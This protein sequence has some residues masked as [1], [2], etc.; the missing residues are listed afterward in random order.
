M[1]DT[2]DKS[3][4]TLVGV[5]S[6]QN[7]ERSLCDRCISVG[8]S[9]DKFIVSKPTVVVD[10]V[11]N[12]YGYEP[13]KS[14]DNFRLNSGASLKNF[15][16]LRE[17]QESRVN[18]AFC[19]LVFRAIERY[20][21]STA[22]DD[23]TSCSLRWEVH[24]READSR[25][26]F[27][28]NSTRRIRFTWNEKLGHTQEVYVIYVAPRD[29]LRPNS[30]A[31]SRWERETLFLGRDFGD[32]KEKQ[33]LIKSWLDLCIH[34]HRD[35]C[36]HTHDSQDE[37]R[38][39]IEETYFGIIDVAD[40]Q[41]KSLPISA[42]GEPEPYV[43]LSYVW[44]RKPH[45]DPPYVTKRANIVTHILHGGLET[46]WEKLPRTIQDSILLV[47]RLGYRYLWIDSLC[48]VQ[49]SDSSWQLNAQAMHLVYGHALFTICAADGRDCSSGLRAAQPILRALDPGPFGG[50][51]EASRDFDDPRPICADVGKGL[52]LM[53]TRPLEAMISDSEWD[54][55]A[56]T[57]QE[58]IL[59]RRCLIFAEGRVFFQCRTTC[60]SQD[61]Y[62]DGN[63]KGWSLDQANSPLRTLRELQQR[64][65]WLYLMYIRMYTGRQLTKPR[66]VLAAFKGVEWLLEEY[67]EAPA[68]FGL[69]TSH[70]D[71]AVLWSPL[72][73]VRR[74]QPRT[75]SGSGTSCVQDALG[76]CI[77]KVEQESFGGNDFP[78]WS[79][80]G[81]MNGKS[82]YQSSMLEGCLVDVRD[83]L[84]HHTWIQWHIRDET[85]HL[86][87]LWGMISHKTNEYIINHRAGTKEDERWMGYPG[88]EDAQPLFIRP[89]SPPPPPPPPPD[90]GELRYH[91]RD[92]SP[93][94]PRG[95]ESPPDRRLMRLGDLLVRVLE[96][97]DNRW[98]TTSWRGPPSDRSN[99]DFE[100]VTNSAYVNNGTTM[101]RNEREADFKRQRRV[102][103]VDP[104]EDIH[105]GHDKYGR[106]IRADV[107]AM[108]DEKTPMFQAI[109][110]DN[111]F[112][113]IRDK[114]RDP[115][116]DRC[117]SP[118]RM[119]KGSRMTYM[120]ILQFK[121]WRTELHVTI[122]DGNFES[123]VRPTNTGLC[124]CDILD[125]PSDWCGAIVLDE[126]WIRDRQGNVFQFIALSGAE[127]F[128]QEECPVWTYYIPKERDESE[129]DLY[130]VLLLQRD[131]ERGVWERVGLGKVFQAA[132]RDRSWAEIKPG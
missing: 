73:A 21:G 104:P 75:P 44:G 99:M 110:P 108:H 100:R 43:A 84:T 127:C 128:T 55:R 31:I 45:D 24:G 23:T 3:S 16:T 38:K 42:N 9:L 28:V 34:D 111:P 33:A 39:L 51:Q 40:M 95:L 105:G 32:Q 1:A 106:H 62:S 130:F 20:S 17:L 22:V 107:S 118:N 60:M 87:P 72:E 10:I 54:T 131:I 47:S 41:L 12:R 30:D 27:A 94:R 86:R 114:A 82:E 14:N 68:L 64:P 124:Q 53:V 57:F 76:N 126:E 89:L 65:L 5:D 119:G 13:R 113:V 19:D 49:D 90:L 85:G 109:L 74:R 102:T 4:L 66:D 97:L 35:E 92:V 117:R 58:R 52:R 121:T 122:R 2:E 101:S 8:F 125:K 48:I 71:L 81:W 96:V 112:G 77:C 56:W 26:A 7:G 69:P 88:I 37:F 70:F 6:T 116:T 15:A 123:S 36:R 80:S 46:A 59:S 50:S 18:C 129:W 98:N 79:W 61:I 120:P 91:Y 132:S 115:P 11:Q 67:M 103:L 93:P 29:A 25:S 63:R 83:W 78:S